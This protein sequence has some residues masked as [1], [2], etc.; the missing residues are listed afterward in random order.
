MERSDTIIL[1][2]LPGVGKTTLGRA[3]SKRVGIPFIDLD[4][5]VEELAEMS[6]KEIFDR[7]GEERFREYER[8]ALQ[9]CPAKAIIATG[10]GTP[11]YGDNMQWMMD[12]GRVVHLTADPGRVII[13]IL[14]AAGTRPMF[15]NLEQSD[16]AQQLD[17]LWKKRKPFYTLTHFS[18]DTTYLDT[19]AELEVAVQSF[20]IQYLKP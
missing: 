10:G 12:H 19:V 20:I 7:Y 2:G 8:Q 11:C 17:N 1:I 3:V 14:D 6:I 5:R 13:R 15:N 4:E 9:S 18:F 16:V